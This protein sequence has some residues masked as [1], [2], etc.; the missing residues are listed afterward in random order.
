DPDVTFNASHTIFPLSLDKALVM[1]NLP[2][3]R[4]PY[5]DPMMQRPNPALLRTSG[6]FNFTHVQTGRVL[7][8]TEVTEI[9]FVIKER[10]YRYV[11]AGERDW[12]YP[13]DHVRM[14]MWD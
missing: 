2:W 4:N 9:N 5:R 12:L 8:E 7:S 13:E 14:R 1:T 3:A 6:V 10:A 11:A